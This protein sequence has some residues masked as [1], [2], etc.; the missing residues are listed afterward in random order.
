MNVADRHAGSDLIFKI[1]I[2]WVFRAMAIYSFLFA[3]LS[4]Y[5]GAHLYG[6]VFGAM[7]FVGVVLQYDQ[8][9]RI[10]KELNAI[11]STSNL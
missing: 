2:M 11:K 3:C 1:S 10:E 9:K 6:I 7:T 4:T 8:G 5:V